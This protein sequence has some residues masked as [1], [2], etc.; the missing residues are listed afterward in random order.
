MSTNPGRVAIVGTGARGLMFVNGISERPDS[1]VVALCDL[2]HV[3]AEYYNSV[4]QEQGRPRAALYKPE[5]FKAMLKKEK[6]ETV[7]VTTVDATHHIYIVAA[8]EEN[9]AFLLQ[10]RPYFSLICWYSACNLR[11]ADDYNSRV[12]P[13]HKPSLQKDRPKHHCQRFLPFFGALFTHTDFS[14]DFQLSLQPSPR[15]RQAFYR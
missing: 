9:G 1:L 2:N 15:T 11:E 12:L 13:H 8:L 7:V 5:Q 10:F 3:R 6:V 14:G 4:L